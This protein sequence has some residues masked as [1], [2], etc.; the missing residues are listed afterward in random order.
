VVK[1][2][3]MSM[4]QELIIKEKEFKDK[5]RGVAME[6]NDAMVLDSANDFP[7]LVGMGDPAPKKND[8]LPV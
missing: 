5:Q 8:N 6:D 1:A 4:R 2:K 3:D 7:S